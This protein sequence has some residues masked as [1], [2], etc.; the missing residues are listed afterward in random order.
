MSRIESLKKIRN[1]TKE[2]M[3][4]F[5]SLIF[6]EEYIYSK[7][8]FIE[9]FRIPTQ[10]QFDSYLLEYK[11]MPVLY[12]ILRDA[13]SQMMKLEHMKSLSKGEMVSLLI[14]KTFAIKDLINMNENLCKE[15][16]N[17]YEKHPE[18]RFYT[19]S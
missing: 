1:L 4:V 17:I 13:H 9:S 5:L 3:K 15:L 14:S 18:C 11:I 6:S 16:E 12:E 19:F 8:E 7:E 2:D 10:E